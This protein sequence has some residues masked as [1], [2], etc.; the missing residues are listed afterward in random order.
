[1][2][3]T[4]RKVSLHTRTT[5]D[6]RAANDLAWLVVATTLG[7]SAAIHFGLTRRV[8]I[9]AAV[10]RWNVDGLIT[11]MLVLPVAL[12][13][14]SVRR[15][16]DASRMEREVAAAGL[17]D[18]LT[19][20]PNRVLL[21]DRLTHAMARSRRSRRQVAVLHVD[22]DRFKLIND[23]RGFTAGDEVLVAVAQLLTR[24][25]RPGDT[26]ARSGGDEF[27]I[28][29]EEIAARADAERIAARITEA[30]AE[31][32]DAGGEPVHVTASIGVA[33]LD[34]RRNTDPEG[35][36]QDADVAM[37]R[38]KEQGRGRTVLYEGSMRGGARQPGLERSLRIALE[39]GPY[40][41]LSP[42][43]VSSAESCGW[44]TSRS[45]P[46]VTGMPKRSRP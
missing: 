23:G 18:S 28:V 10:E 3:S 8:D 5:R 1:M 7:C 15:W 6:G 24:C 43:L 42:P 11:L 41:L 46:F 30:L 39:Q 2:R 22:I 31:P 34:D 26:V 17:R 38:A 27:T 45:S 14:F 44:P 16:N 29:C 20:L 21:G 35:L 32:I 36:L 37:Y 33:L 9:S 19:G 12:A 40:R 4:S 13:V 25:T